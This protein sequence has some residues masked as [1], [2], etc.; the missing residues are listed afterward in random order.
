MKLSLSKAC[1]LFTFLFFVILATR[2][3][4]DENAAK[5]V[6][7]KVASK[8]VKTGPNPPASPSNPAVIYV[9]S[10][11]EQETNEQYFLNIGE[12]EGFTYIE[13][14][15]YVLRVS[16]TAIKNPPADGS[17]ISFKLIQVVSKT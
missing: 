12:I 9:M 2:C 10:I 3:K 17:S 6:T 11:T 8:L 15:E 7:M 4:K 14:Y 1:I 16:K 13:G 5:V